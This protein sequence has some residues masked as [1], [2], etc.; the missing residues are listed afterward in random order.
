MD[1]TLLI[2]CAVVTLY[3]SSCCSK[4]SNPQDNPI[5]PLYGNK[6][7]ATRGLMTRSSGTVY[8]TSRIMEDHLSQLKRQL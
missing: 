7:L 6:S 8:T 3:D 5:A 1:L 2:S 4:S